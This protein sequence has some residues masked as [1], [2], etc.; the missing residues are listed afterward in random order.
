[1]NDVLLD[2]FFPPK[3]P[4]AP[5]PSLRPHRTAPPRRTEEIADSLAKYSP[6]LAPGSDGITYSAWKQVNR[7]NPLI[8]LQA[9]A[10][11]V[12]LGYHPASL[13]SSNGVVLDKAGK[14]S[15]ECPS[16]F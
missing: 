13:K 4:F 16:S 2:H 14:P 3:E 7:I 12:S 10:L 11:L 9:L 5:P 15:Y 6:T 8:H 1:M